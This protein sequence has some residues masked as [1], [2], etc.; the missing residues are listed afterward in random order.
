MK[1][2]EIIEVMETYLVNVRPPEEIRNK[3]DINY[4][5]EGQSIIVFEIRPVWNNPTEKTECN[6]AKTTYV[7]KDNKWNIYWFMSDM[8]WHSYQ[9]KPKVSKLKD[10]V[11]E[12]EED[13]HGCFW[14]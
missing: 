1:H 8:K 11:K 10:F 4:K 2:L 9:P 14:G 6:I 7:K 3:V 13:K 12:I 5:I